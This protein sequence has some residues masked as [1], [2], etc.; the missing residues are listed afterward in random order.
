MPVAAPLVMP[1]A[2]Y[3]AFAI[4][5][6][7]GT[8]WGQ[9]APS[10]SV[11]AF[12]GGVKLSEQSFELLHPDKTALV[13]GADRDVHALSNDGAAP[14]IG[15]QY[16]YG[17]ARL[18]WLGTA[19]VISTQPVSATVAAGSSPSFTVAG[20]ADPAPSIRWQSRTPGSSAFTDVDGA[21]GPTLDVTA[22]PE[23][24]GT[25]YRAVLTNPA[26]AVASDVAT[27]QVTS[28]P[29]IVLPPTSVTAA[30]GGTATF[31][32]VASGFPEPTITWQRD[33]DGAWTDVV[34]SSSV[35]VDDGTLQLLGLVAE[36]DGQQY[37]A[38]AT[39]S[40]GSDQSPPVTLTVTDGGPG[41]G[42]DD[43]TIGVTVPEGT[44]PGEFV[45][46][47]DGNGQVVLSEA[48]NQGGYWQSTGEIDP[49]S[50][51]DSRAGGLSWSISG[52]VGDF[53]GGIDGKHL[54]WKPKVTV[55]G[56]GAAPGDEVFSG[57]T[58][59][60]GLKDGSLLASRASGN[61]AGGTATLGADLDLRLPI[62][63]G[64][65]TYSVTLTI[66]ALS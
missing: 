51:S 63:T 48:A 54:G 12:R 3:G 24:N 18:D 45:W 32:V 4:D 29:A 57:I 19:P 11:A 20:T 10:R 50:V 27:L 41:P 44:G 6:V 55:A 5:P 31:E 2:T 43:M 58:S 8:V 62:T 26:G 56:A 37:R 46:S 15:I 25:E 47:I 60:N 65:G 52:Q 22:T 38:V 61:T 17:F 36:Q 14:D 66:T 33:I 40:V 64:A 28:A 21:T 30:I 53:T 9:S 13:V 16:K 49:I 23:G 42:S 39:N 59:G 35:V 34:P 1:G 7:D